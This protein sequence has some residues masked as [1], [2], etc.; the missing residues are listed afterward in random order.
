MASENVV[1][2]PENFK[3]E[4]E[5][6]GEFTG[7]VSTIY[8]KTFRTNCPKCAEARKAKE[9]Q[10]EID[11][12]TKQERERIQRK[13]GAAM[14]PHRFVS[15]TFADYKA[16]GDG[17]KKALSICKDYADNFRAHFEE[18]R[19]LL[20]LG[21]P[22]TGK[23]HLAAA[24]A[25]QLVTTTAATAI[26]RTVGGILQ[27]VK[28]S[29]D[30][31]SGYS[32]K[33]AFDTYGQANLLIIDEVGATK[34]TEFE[35]A[36]LFAIINARYEQQMPTVIISNLPPKSLPEALGERCVDRLREGGGIALTFDWQ[37]ARKAA[38]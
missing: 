21:K 34:P 14:I 6:H 19:C 20:L 15:K 4:C 2:L 25:N 38:L 32:E 36:T 9:A 23:T 22:G 8:G 29:F 7:S 17:Q 28:G 12:Q 10:D 13:L 37:S 18:G 35:L 31:E 26:Y 5:Q 30:R 16:D 24:I 27:H 33:Q 1:S 3:G 11:A